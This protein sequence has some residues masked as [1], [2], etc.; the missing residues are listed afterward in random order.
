ME[1]ALLN[2]F[3]KNVVE[4]DI[5]DPLVAQQIMDIMKIFLDLREDFSIDFHTRAKKVSTF[6]KLNKN[7]FA[8]LRAN[9]LFPH[10]KEYLKKN[11]EE[12]LK[13]FGEEERVCRIKALQTL[14]KWES[15][16]TM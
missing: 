9:P 2:F 4:V 3:F 12:I 8:L 11:S 15:S 5:R 10:F 7:I 14:L 13:D 1:N 16:S 6:K